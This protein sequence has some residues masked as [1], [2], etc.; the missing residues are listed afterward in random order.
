MLNKQGY[1][2]YNQ[3][4]ILKND[5]MLKNDQNCLNMLRAQEFY[6]FFDFGMQS[7]LTLDVLNNFCHLLNVVKILFKS[8]RKN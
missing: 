4:L 1:T 3:K 7:L 2:Y 6:W 5:Q 8:I